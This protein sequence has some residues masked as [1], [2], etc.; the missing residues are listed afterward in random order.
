MP[1]GEKSTHVNQKIGG[2]KTH[3]QGHYGRPAEK[4]LK[5]FSLVVRIP[6]VMTPER[7]PCWVI[8][9]QTLKGDGI[10]KQ[11]HLNNFMGWAVPGGEMQPFNSLSSIPFKTV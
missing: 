4:R 5:V 1:N 8:A 7:R 9:T 2:T 6:K 3:T 11:G 10:H